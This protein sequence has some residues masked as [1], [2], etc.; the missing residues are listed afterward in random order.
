[1]VNKNKSCG[2]NS[3]MDEL[4]LTKYVESGMTQREISEKM[5]CS[6]STIRHWMNKFKLKSKNFKIGDDKFFQSKRYLN[7]KNNSK[8]KNF[9]EIQSLY[10]SG[11]SWHDVSKKVKICLATIMKYTKIGMLKSRTASE[12]LK[13]SK[14]K[15]PKQKHSEETKLKI[16]A[17]RKKWLTENPDKH[18]W[19][20][21]SF[22]HSSIPC[23]RFKTFLREQNIDFIDEFMPLTHI[24][25]FFRID[26]AFPDKKIAIEVNGNQHYDTNGDLKPYYKNRQS[27]LEEHGWIVY[28]VHHT[29]CFKF[30]KLS[31]FMEKIK[32]SETKIEFDYFN[33][34]PKE[35]KKYFC[36]C[37]NIITKYSK[38]CLKCM[39]FKN[40]KVKQPS[41][42]ELEKLIWEKPLTELGKQFGVSDNAVRA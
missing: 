32:N 36:S 9:K 12:S 23:E 26:I 27:I 17:A 33:Y 22:V 2:V 31:E 5:N 7:S 30:E 8:I 4:T 21:K 40:R 20:N 34:V 19:K 39:G 15:R 38:K 35:K 6:Q 10:D 13:I 28:Q 11:L 25:R 41:K 42:E 37:G 3:N 16:S 29:A 18:P 14:D 24:G 1:V